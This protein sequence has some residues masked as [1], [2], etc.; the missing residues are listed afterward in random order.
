MGTN[1]RHIVALSGG[2]DSSAMALRLMETEPQD[3]E[4]V[5]TPTGDE[6]PEMIEH[7]KKLGERL[8]KPLRVVTAGKS[9]LGLIRKHEML[10]NFR[11]RFCT[12]E[13][14]IKP[15]IAFMLEAAPAVS[16]VGLRAD[17]DTE[18]RQGAV[19]GNVDGITQRFPLREWGWGLKEVLGYLD[20]RGVCVPKRT[21]CAICFYQTLAE[22]HTLWKEYPERFAAGEAEEE[23]LGHT[24]RSDGRDT[25]PAALKDLRLR[26]ESGDVP[27]RSY[28][29]AE[30]RRGMCRA[31]SM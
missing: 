4:F 24:L 2:K 15:Y 29:I 14:K 22:W 5:I 13:I 25:W 26:F 20:E 28:Q 30:K 1:T 6:L 3:Y 21:D 8:G 10:P 27:T 7:W 18:T 19:Y 12:S 11:A 17:E 23:R 16:Y 31:C 9:L